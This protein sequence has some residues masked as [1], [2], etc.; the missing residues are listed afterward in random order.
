M[1]LSKKQKELVEEDTCT[2]RAEWPVAETIIYIT[3]R[4]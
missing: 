2:K 3:A 1:K 4:N